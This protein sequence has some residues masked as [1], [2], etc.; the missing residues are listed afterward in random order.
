[1]TARR[2]ALCGGSDFVGVSREIVLVQG[3]NQGCQGEVS[4]LLEKRMMFHYYWLIEF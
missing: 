4:M 1:M 2:F 3:M